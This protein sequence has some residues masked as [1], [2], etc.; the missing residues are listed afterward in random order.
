M[1]CWFWFCWNWQKQSS[2]MCVVVVKFSLQ[3]S[4]YV[5]QWLWW[6]FCIQV[7]TSHVFKGYV[8]GAGGL[9]HYPLCALGLEAFLYRDKLNRNE[10]CCHKVV[11]AWIRIVVKAWMRFMLQGCFAFSEISERKWKTGLYSQSFVYC[12]WNAEWKNEAHLLQGM[13]TKQNELNTYNAGRPGMLSLS[14]LQIESLV[15]TRGLVVSSITERW[16][17]FLGDS[18]QHLNQLLTLSFFFL[19]W[20]LLLLHCWRTESG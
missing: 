16:L 7:V 15:F 10:T 19:P 17:H 14:Q 20:L 2:S 6:M 18:F 9:N 13:V 12:G 11:A 3:S 8:Q 1:S 5:L 4:T